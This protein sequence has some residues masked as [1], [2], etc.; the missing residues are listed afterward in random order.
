[1]PDMSNFLPFATTHSRPCLTRDFSFF[2]L[3]LSSAKKKHT[4]EDIPH[5]GRVAALFVLFALWL[6]FGPRF[7]KK[8]CSLRRCRI[9][10]VFS[11]V[12]FSGSILGFST[13]T[14]TTTTTTMTTN[15][16]EGGPAD[17]VNACPDMDDSML[18]RDLDRVVASGTRRLSRG[19]ESLM[20]IF[21]WLKY[22][23]FSLAHSLSSLALGR[24]F[25]LRVVLF[26]ATLGAG[27]MGVSDFL[28]TLTSGMFTLLWEWLVG[29]VG[30][31][32]PCCENGQ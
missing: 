26:K 25:L 11:E 7:N 20:G 18:A 10:H 1:M 12:S 27:G 9:V 17:I 24:C 32:F 22:L 21:W 13:T 19:S 16:D 6:Y 2:F 29:E 30:R 4:R 8:F 31:C 14:T 15:D 3:Q 23:I 28:T 5:E